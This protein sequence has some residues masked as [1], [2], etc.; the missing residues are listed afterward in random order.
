MEG[1][2]VKNPSENAGCSS[3]YAAKYGEHRN[4][5]HTTW[6]QSHF[7]SQ[8]MLRGHTMATGCCHQQPAAVEK[9]DKQPSNTCILRTHSRTYLPRDSRRNN[10]NK[11]HPQ[12]KCLHTCRVWSSKYTIYFRTML[13]LRVQMSSVSLKFQTCLIII[14]IA[15]TIRK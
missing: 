7:P 5:M 11:S 10:R 15:K 2:A 3:R 1:H 9:Q 8:A 14:F 13:D 4:T 12:I 6:T